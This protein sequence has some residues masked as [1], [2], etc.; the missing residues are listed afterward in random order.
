MN[1][2]AA[3]LLVTLAIGTLAFTMALV[4][5]AWVIGLSIVEKVALM[6]PGVLLVRVAAGPSVGWL[7]AVT[8]GPLLGVALSSLP[9]LGFWLAG[10]FPGR[11]VLPYIL[12]QCGGAVVASGAVRLLFPDALR[13]GFALWSAGRCVSAAR[14]GDV[15]KRYNI[16][17]E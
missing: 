4:A 10:R 12:A 17:A 9:L 16:K 6:L 3:W 5:P 2:A 11:A 1:G 15:V 8:F 14:W 13:L 7:P